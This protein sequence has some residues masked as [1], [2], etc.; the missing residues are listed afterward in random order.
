[1]DAATTF[2]MLAADLAGF[3]VSYVWRGHGSAIFF[4]FGELTSRR[5]RD[6]SAGHPEGQVSLGVYRSW[7][8]EDETA[9]LCGSWSD[10]G[11]WEQSLNRLRDARI[12]GVS[13]FGTLPEVEF[14]TEE[15]TRFLSF[16]TTDG[17]PQWHLVDRRETPARWFTVREGRLHLG[18][19]SEPALQ[20]NVRVR[21]LRT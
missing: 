3:P 4:E 21:P 12:T 9:I 10:E 1:M 20:S 2:A 15:G 13:V 17:Q 5:N 6:G 11:L 8:I 18:D 19:G 14:V 16:S 7:R